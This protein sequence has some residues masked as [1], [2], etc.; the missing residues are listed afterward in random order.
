MHFVYMIR[1]SHGNLY[2]GVTDNP[3]QR[4]KYHNENR[5]AKFTKRDTEFEIVFL[6]EYATLAQARK[7]EIQIKKWRRDKK[8]ALIERYQHRLPT[9]L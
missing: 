5:G 4:L 6:E 8:D 9:K 3:S 7:R 2:T 1:N